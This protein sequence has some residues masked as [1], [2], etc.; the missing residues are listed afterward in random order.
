LILALDPC[1]QKRGAELLRGRKVVLREKRLEDAAN[2]YAWRCDEELAHYDAA[3]T[4]R[5]SFDDFLADYADE[6][7]H[8]SR[9]RRRFAIENLEGRHIGNLMYYDIDE[10]KGK[11]E[12]GIMVGD[13]DYQD[14]GYGT[15]AIT[16]LLHHI[17]STTTLN[18]IYLNTLDWNL[19]AQSC[20]KKCGFVPCGQA[21]RYTGTFV[22]MEI[23]RS[24]WQGANKQSLP[25][26]NEP[27]DV[28]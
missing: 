1:G 10:V 22:V 3:P 15:D 8:P 14:K 21:K 7:R 27:N 20:F 16:T 6:L 17:F 23:H 25:K 11:A 19:R 5:L 24:S 18:K 9:Q 2:D 13:R 4:L 26:I 28:P 12:L